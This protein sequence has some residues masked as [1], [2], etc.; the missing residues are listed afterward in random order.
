MLNGFHQKP[1]KTEH[2]FRSVFH[3][4]MDSVFRKFQAYPITALLP[5]QML[6]PS[7]NHF[8]SE[9]HDLFGIHLLPF[10]SISNQTGRL[11]DCDLKGG[12]DHGLA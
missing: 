2:P 12:L 9:K 1:R 8:S 5:S 6:D 10:A 11:Q 7:Q 3:I 4:I